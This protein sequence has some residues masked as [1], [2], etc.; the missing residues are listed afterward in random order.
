M[1]DDQ[2]L[3]RDGFINIINKLFKDNNIELKAP[4]RNAIVKVFSEQN[5]EASLCKNTKGEIEPNTNLRDAERVPLDEDIDVYFKREVQP[6]NSEAWI[7]K[8]KTQV[9]YEIPFTRYFYKFEEPES[10]D[11]ISNRIV[12]LERDIN[13]SL[14]KLFSE[15]GERID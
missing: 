5:D 12:E 1:I 8:E 14:R 11:E 4:L 13:E 3:D 15:D 10:A 6:Y 2:W 9:G 7:D